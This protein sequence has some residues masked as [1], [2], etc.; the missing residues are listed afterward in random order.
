MERRINYE[1]DYK[2][3][4][5][6]GECYYDDTGIDL[7]KYT[8]TDYYKQTHKIVRGNFRN[9][10]MK[11]D[12]A[13]FWIPKRIFGNYKGYC[14]KLWNTYIPV[15]EKNND[16]QEID[17]I[18]LTEYGIIGLECKHRIT[19]VSFPEIE[20]DKWYDAVNNEFYS[21]LKQNRKHLEALQ[22]YLADN[23]PEGTPY[24]NVICF[25]CEYKNMAFYSEHQSVVTQ[26]EY[27]H[28]NV[29]MGDTYAVEEKLNKLFQNSER[30]LS[31]NILDEIY[32]KLYPN[33]QF[34]S[35][36][37]KKIVEK[38]IERHGEK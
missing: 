28:K 32:E 27:N 6:Y 34:N 37:K 29:I 22:K 7:A 17:V 13:E 1:H 35:E 33:T 25:L 12:Y 18:V 11:G 19:P 4:P 21:P 36:K 10:Q 31:L 5:I 30:V 24:I 2:E 14:K 38:I 23:V 8:G 20:A 3:M 26:Y 9:A 16:Y 15:N